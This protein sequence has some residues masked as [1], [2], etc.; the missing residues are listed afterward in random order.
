MDHQSIT[1]RQSVNN[2]HSVNNCQS[3]TNCKFV[4]NNQPSPIG[5]LSPNVPTDKPSVSGRT[6]KRPIEMLNASKVLII[7]S[8]IGDRQDQIDWPAETKSQIND[9]H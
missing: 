8:Q 1:N 4:T 6:D 5:N 7:L 2:C 9:S 3:I